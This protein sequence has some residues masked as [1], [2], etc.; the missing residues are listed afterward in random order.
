MQYPA[1]LAG[2]G[3]VA[4]GR[5]GREVVPGPGRRGREDGAGKTRAGDAGPDG[6]A[7]T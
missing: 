7:A 4:A 1:A 2:R 3:A 6:T 5:A